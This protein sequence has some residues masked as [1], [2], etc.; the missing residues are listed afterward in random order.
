MRLTT[1]GALSMIAKVA[2]VPLTGG[3]FAC[4]SL[5][6][7]KS[8]GDQVHYEPDLAPHHRG[9]ILHRRPCALRGLCCRPQGVCEERTAYGCV[10]YS[11]TGSPELARPPHVPLDHGCVHTCAVHSLP[12]QGRCPVRLGPLPWDRRNSAHRL[13]SLSLHPLFVLP[14]LQV[15]LA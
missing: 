4:R 6:R 1:V 3:A 5:F 15:Y 11:R 2:I 10:F 7:A 9:I 8:F 12:S 13:H 14:R